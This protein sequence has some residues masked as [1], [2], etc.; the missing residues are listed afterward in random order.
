MRTWTVSYTACRKLTRYQR[1]DMTVTFTEAEYEE[2]FGKI[3]AAG[4][5]GME[6]EQ[7][8]VE[9]G[10]LMLDADTW[11]TYGD[12]VEMLDESD[13]DITEGAEKQFCQDASGGSE[14]T[15]AVVS[16]Q[17]EKEKKCADTDQASNI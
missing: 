17:Q 7:L 6:I 16:V 2:T 10:E 12:M 1:Q 15:I 11:E 5:D 3:P 13:F 8:A 4:L 14:P 9:K